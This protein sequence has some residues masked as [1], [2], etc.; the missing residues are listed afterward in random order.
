VAD[1][2]TVEDAKRFLKS[3]LRN[4]IVAQEAHFADHD[5]YA[6]SMREILRSY[7]PSAG[8]TV[9]MLTSTEKSHSAIATDERVPGLVCATYIGNAPPP[10][11]T[12][13]EG[14]VVCRDP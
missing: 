11:G 13:A 6:L 10:M 14:E 1:S 5:R 8:V 3:D 2:A 12:G 4:F 9:V 7:R